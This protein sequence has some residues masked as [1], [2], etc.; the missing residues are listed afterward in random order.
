MTLLS[1]QTI[2]QAIVHPEPAIR[3]IALEYF[4]DGHSRDATVMPKV[5]EAV[6]TCGWRD[7]WKL[8]DD[9]RALPQTAATFS[10]ACNELAQPYDAADVEADN[11]HLALGRLVL[12]SPPPLLLAER[13]QALVNLRGHHPLVR[14]ALSERLRLYRSDWDAC[15]A[16]LERVGREVRDAHAYDREHGR[17][18]DH[19]NQALVWHGRGRGAFVLDLVHRRSPATDSDL[20]EMLLPQFLELAGR[21]GL[22]GAVAELVDRVDNPHDGIR[23]AACEALRRIGG[24]AV[25]TQ[26]AR[27]WPE[28]DGCFR[29][30]LTTPLGR[31][32][33][34]RSARQCLAWHGQECEP[35]VVRDLSYA[36]LSHFSTAAVEQV[37]PGV[38]GQPWRLGT[39]GRELRRHLV[40]VATVMGVRFGEYEPWY[41][42]AVNGPDG[43]HAPP[44][45]DE[46]RA[47][48]LADR[49]WG[50]TE[51][52]CIEERRCKVYQLKVV[53]ADTDP[54][55]W[56]RLRVPDCRLDTLHDVLRHTMGWSDLPGCVFRA[57]GRTYVGLDQAGCGEGVEKARDIHLS[58]V[59]LRVGDQLAYVCGLTR[60][61]GHIITVEKITTMPVELAT[62]L[63]LDGGPASWR[64][65]RSPTA[66]A[67][68][69]DP[70]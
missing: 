15:W 30:L 60:G 68:V 8:L 19:L 59:A 39:E 5:V 35:S 70:A 26:I 63:Y 47:Y 69:C 34:E 28:A 24:E 52:V 25:V 32:P 40:A 45:P 23:E 29:S 50:Q 20:H 51:P 58:D 61:R 3:S 1:A 38:R 37:V 64:R 57:R 13:E 48:R 27:V 4:T 46:P 36:A 56:C 31:I 9:A 2:K 17:L 22:V 62:P 41:D 14:Q 49:P 44:E 53:L 42:E 33:T 6:R 12:E 55:V 67:E 18:L 21:M 54:P 7:T 11:Y 65:R 66:L 10:W 43:W 16:E